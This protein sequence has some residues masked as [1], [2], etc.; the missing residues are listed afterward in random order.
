[1]VSPLL[2]SVI[3]LASAFASLS[4]SGTPSVPLPSSFLATGGSPLTG[5]AQPL[6][7]LASFHIMPALPTTGAPQYPGAYPIY[8]CD[9]VL[10]ESV[11]GAIRSA[12]FLVSRRSFGGDL[13]YEVLPK[14]SNQL[15][16]APA[17]S[18][19]LASSS[20]SS[21]FSSASSV[22]TSGG[23]SSSPPLF[24]TPGMS[25]HKNYYDAVL[26]AARDAVDHG[27]NSYSM[28]F[29]ALI[30]DDP[31]FPCPYYL[32]VQPEIADRWFEEPSSAD[33]V[34]EL[35]AGTKL[36]CFWASIIAHG[37][38]SG[39][40]C[41]DAIV[42]GRAV[43][44]VSQQRLMIP[45]ISA[46]SLLAL[47]NTLSQR[48]D[49]FK[50]S[51]IVWL[52]YLALALSDDGSGILSADPASQSALCE[53][54][55]V[56]NCS[57]YMQF[58]FRDARRLYERN[59]SQQVT[60][61]SGSGIAGSAPGQAAAAF[62]VTAPAAVGEH[63]LISFELI[64]ELNG[65]RRTIVKNALILEDCDSAYLGG[66]LGGMTDADMNAIHILVARGCEFGDDAAHF[67]GSFGHLEY[68][69]LNKCSLVRLPATLLEN[70]TRLLWC[71][72]S[73][74]FIS[75]IPAGFF[76]HTPNLRR[77]DLSGNALTAIEDGLRALP[78]LTYFSASDNADLGS[79]P[80]TAFEGSNHLSVF[81]VAR[82]GALSAI[83]GAVWDRIANSV[84]YFLA[85]DTGLDG[86][87][88]KTV[89]DSSARLKFAWYP[90]DAELFTTPDTDVRAALVIAGEAR[91]DRNL[92]KNAATFAIKDVAS[93]GGEPAAPAALVLDVDKLPGY[94]PRMASKDDEVAVIVGHLKYGYEDLDH[95]RMAVLRKYDDCKAA[96]TAYATTE[97]TTKHAAA[98]EA[99][100][101]EA[102]AAHAAAEV[103]YNTAKAKYDDD[104][105]A[106]EAGNVA[107]AAYAADNGPLAL[108]VEALAKV[109]HTRITF[110]WRF[111][112]MGCFKLGKLE[113]RE[114]RDALG[115]F[116]GVYDESE[117]VNDK[118]DSYLPSLYR[119]STIK[120]EATDIDI[121]DRFIKVDD[122]PG[123]F[124]RVLYMTPEARLQWKELYA[125]LPVLDAL[126]GLVRMRLM[127]D[128]V[129]HVWQKGFVGDAERTAC[130]AAEGGNAVFEA[131]DS[132]MEALLQ[133]VTKCSGA[134]AL[135]GVMTDS[136]DEV[137]VQAEM[138]NKMRR[139]ITNAQALFER[140]A[141]TA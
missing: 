7:R 101:L 70:S 113:V 75:R 11:A 104:K 24:A 18:A 99:E 97:V 98:E 83:D 92:V 85:Q 88:L 36:E 91:R 141:A 4:A 39:I 123:H 114:L 32:H 28:L 116:G 115:S 47:V 100:K 124:C 60:V 72:V 96:A 137:R 2:T 109:V 48:P 139:R 5:P 17:P 73:E 13:E 112:L 107:A 87:T 82:C 66:V 71:D 15:V 106:M 94:G 110:L 102:Q 76:A 117:E 34:C 23:A 14:E 21:Q 77:I 9:E 105:A 44:S 62:T 132:M 46:T 50:R 16:A 74:N 118:F 135:L 40:Q 127:N 93:L 10:K 42:L 90:G 81:N 38:K 55:D 53:A 58:C 126:I 6:R 84:E 33:A 133:V 52:A 31:Q 45:D 68:L 61:F 37:D 134:I 121:L 120:L 57:T 59:T 12:G 8:C 27:V 129:K 1:M 79:L 43:I 30:S 108:A 122:L 111:A 103:A 26:R 41:D 80:D 136:D 67:V 89:F 119:A 3:C 56:L 128:P 130:H 54:F 138:F 35:P 22:V 29:S 125:L 25:A 131:S 20:A 86:T 65:R 69:F 95:R 63:K 140:L 64:K 19:P 78:E 49:V 51:Y